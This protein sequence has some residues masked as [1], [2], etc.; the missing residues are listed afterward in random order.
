MDLGKQQVLPVGWRQVER[1]E[2]HGTGA[3]TDGKVVAVMRITADKNG[4]VALHILVKRNN[5]T[6]PNGKEMKKVRRD[7]M[8]ADRGRIVEN[9]TI[10]PVSDQVRNIWQVFDT[11]EKTKSEILNPQGQPYEN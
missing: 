8:D 4:R 10:L 1:S 6:R 9:N 2:E 7:L 3:F 11:D 5:G